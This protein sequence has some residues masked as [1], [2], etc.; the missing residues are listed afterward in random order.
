MPN[1]YDYL[2]F[3]QYLRDYYAEQKAKNPHFSY[4]SFTRLAGFKA[5]SLIHN[6]LS[7]K[8]NV[9]KDGV[10]QIGNALK[11]G[12]KELAFFQ[13]LVDF[14]QATEPSTRSLH[15]DKLC[16]A[17]PHSPARKLQQNSYEYY[18]QWYFPAIR[19][20]ACMV[21]FEKDFEKLGRSLKPP[22]GAEQAR[23][24]VDLL[25]GL[26]LLEK[27]RTGYRQTSTSVTT[28]DEVRSLAVADY[29]RQNT[30]LAKL[31][32]DST[33]AEERDITSLTMSISKATFEAIKSEVRACR[34][35]IAQLANAETAPSRIFHLNFHFFP[36][37]AE[38]ESPGGE[39]I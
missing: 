6:I 32:I 39:S 36:T 38:L 35:R 3:R 20:L 26:G 23:R 37:S 11:L 10:F 18:S 22:I 1:I 34:R 21:R 9:S 14:G 5:K 27:T 12:R 4:E 8:R 28:G 13:V 25:V 2:D 33:P 17:S 30:D 31:A 16:E 19:E 7:G 29:H 24:A 15:F